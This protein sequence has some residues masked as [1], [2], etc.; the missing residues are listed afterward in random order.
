MVWIRSASCQS[1]EIRADPDALSELLLD[2]ERCGLMMPTV[3]SLDRVQDGDGIYRYVLEEIS[4]GAVSLAAD[5]ESRFDTSDRAAISWEPHGE[6]NF[7]S[8]GTFRTSAGG[9]PGEVV[10]EIDTRSEADVQV[11]AA[12]IPLVEPFAQQASDEITKV[13]LHNIKDSVE[14]ADGARA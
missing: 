9:V 2:I 13:F 6:H 7:R 8:W 12:L 5:Y 3:R 1:I 10:L 4:N 11:D 14:G